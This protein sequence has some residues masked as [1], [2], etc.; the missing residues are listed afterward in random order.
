MNPCFDFLPLKGHQIHPDICVLILLTSAY[1][2]Q[3]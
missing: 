2:M 3:V 1:L